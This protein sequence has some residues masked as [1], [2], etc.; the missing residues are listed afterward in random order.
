[1]DTKKVDL[2]NLCQGFIREQNIY[3]E[4]TVYQA[5]R[6]I[7]NAYKFIADICKIVG[8]VDCDEEN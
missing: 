8:Y 1:M 5:D 4:E 7:V 6:I 2:Y 3:A